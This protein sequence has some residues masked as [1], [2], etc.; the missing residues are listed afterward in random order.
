[1]VAVGGSGH[2][3]RC[4]RARP[5][6]SSLPDCQL[7]MVAVRSAGSPPWRRCGARPLRRPE[8]RCERGGG[9]CRA[10]R[11]A[12]ARFWNACPATPFFPQR[13]RASSRTLRVRACPFV[14]LCIPA[15]LHGHTPVRPVR[16]RGPGC[17]FLSP[18][19]CHGAPC[20]PPGLG[21]ASAFLAVTCWAANACFE[22]PFKS[23]SIKTRPGLPFLGCTTSTT[24]H[25][26]SFAS[27]CTSPESA[28]AGRWS[29][30]A[31]QRTDGRAP[32]PARQPHLKEAPFRSSRAS[33]AWPTRPAASRRKRAVRTALCCLR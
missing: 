7:F 8:G 20:M 25:S 3:G 15:R 5:A 2:V 33:P 4:H 6:G 19:I 27:A 24:S 17:R 11:R 21:K 32:Q 12:P 18:Q 26:P 10:P 29:A 14:G 31:C 13:Q 23:R 9:D 16:E 1:M 22:G 28:S 30:R